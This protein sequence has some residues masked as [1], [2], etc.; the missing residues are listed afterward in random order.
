MYDKQLAESNTVFKRFGY[1]TE[2][3][4]PSFLKQKEIFNKLTDEWCD[5]ILKLRERINYVDHYKG[6]NIGVKCFYGFDNAFSFSKKIRDGYIT[7]EKAKE[8]QSDSKS[9]LNEI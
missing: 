6:K 1:D 8:N 4:S 7:L 9:D 5:E 3:D 2:K